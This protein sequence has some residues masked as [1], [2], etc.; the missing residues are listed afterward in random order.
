MNKITVSLVLML[1]SL[2]IQAQVGKVGINTNFPKAMLHVRDSSVLFTGPPIVSP[3]PNDPPITG[4][5]IRMMW[6]PEK[7]AFRSGYVTNYFWDKDSIGKYTF[8]VGYDTKAKGVASAAMGMNAFASGLSSISMGNNTIASGNYSVALG[9]FTKATGVE[10]FATGYET[11]ASSLASTALGSKTTASGKHSTAMGNF[12][13]ASGESSTSM[14]NF[15]DAL[16]T[17]S[18]SMGSVTTALGKYS[19]SFGS[20]TR[21]IGDNSISMG[22]STKAKGSQ[23]TSMGLGTIANSYGLLALGRY[24]DSISTSNNLTWVPTDPVFLIGNGTSMTDRK[25]AM[26]VYKN[27]NTHI[28]GNLKIYNGNV[29]TGAVLTAIDT[30]GNTEWKSNAIGFSATSSVDFTI[31]NNVY[32]NLIY[33]AQS[34]DE[35]GNNY[36]ASTGIYT[37]PTTGMYHFDISVYW[38][39]LTG[40]ENLY[41]VINSE[42]RKFSSTQVTT[43]GLHTQKISVLTKLNAGTTVGVQV[44]QNSGSSVIIDNATGGSYFTAAKVY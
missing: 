23:S 39:G 10:S 6:Y 40:T 20:A 43:T 18:V 38:N 26:V 12:T 34:L 27:G 35:G 37:I 11:I 3:A 29:T 4:P 25:N 5:G 36:N 28:N 17:G 9:H 13:L 24:N 19:A 15:T 30:F 7:A 31:A 33:N 21:A 14:G 16:G 32:V 42:R 41:L 8:A 22:E 2:C 44:L 1:L